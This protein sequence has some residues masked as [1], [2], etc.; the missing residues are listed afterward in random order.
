MVAMVFAE[1]GLLTK[2]RICG[3]NDTFVAM[4]H[5]KYL[6]HLFGIDGEGLKNSMLEM[7]NE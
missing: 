7:L 4:A 1:E 6:Y 2:F 3:I 5:A